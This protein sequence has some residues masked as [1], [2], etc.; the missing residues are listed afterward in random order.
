MAIFLSLAEVAV[1]WSVPRKQIE[2][3][4]KEGQLP[5]YDLAGS[6]RVFHADLL[7]Y[8]RSMRRSTSPLL[9][10]QENHG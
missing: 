2:V 9:R 5:V 7:D 4:I 1:R 10:P 6:E 3:L 8:E